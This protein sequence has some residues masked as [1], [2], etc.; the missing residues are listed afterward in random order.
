MTASYW[1][2][3]LTILTSCTQNMV[4]YPKSELSVCLMVDI[5]VGPVVRINPR[6]IHIKDP[7][8]FHQIYTNSIKFDKDP[9]Y[10]KFI[11]ITKSTFA[12]PD[13]RRHRFR[14]RA[15]S[16]PFSSSM[17]LSQQPFIESCVA[18]LIASVKNAKPGQPINLSQAYWCLA[19]DVV[20]GCMMSRTSRLL[21][22]PS[23]APQFGKM[24]K[25]LARLALRN[26]HFSWLFSILLWVPRSIVRQVAPAAVLDSLN[27]EHVSN[28]RNKDP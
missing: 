3:S 22:D 23:S 1:A 10:Y 21:D 11:G 15:M 14:R 5:A 20:T 7:A 18:K 24:F 13:S 27:I 19:N 6:E 4:R 12:T 26:R 9:W 17:I 16:N 25:A 28:P 8:F 2:S